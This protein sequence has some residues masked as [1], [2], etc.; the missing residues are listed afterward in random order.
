MNP[1]LDFIFRRRSIR[2]YAPGRKPI[3]ADLLRDLLEAGMAAPSAR[4]T[5]PWRV[6]VA[7]RPELLDQFG[8]ILPNGKAMLD[9]VPVFLLVCGDLCAACEGKESYLLQDCA[10]LTEN[11]LLAAAALGLGS[12]WIGI[13]PWPHRIEPIREQLK[14]PPEIL[15]FGG[16]A[17][18]WPDETKEPRTR[19]NPAHVRHNGWSQS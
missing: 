19:F 7:D 16:I 11:I 2:R 12:C 10:A 5:Q 15:P 8:A 14:L 3:Q 9:Q 1:T 4:D 6:V 13:H 18:G 17:I